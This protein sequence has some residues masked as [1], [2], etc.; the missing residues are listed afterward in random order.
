MSRDKGQHEHPV[1]LT[2]QTL[3]FTA[4]R[5]RVITKSAHSIP[6]KM[7]FSFLLCLDVLNFL[8]KVDFGN[9]EIEEDLISD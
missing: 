9:C 7:F 8:L 3:C 6:L 5:Q 1:D 2:N 4:E